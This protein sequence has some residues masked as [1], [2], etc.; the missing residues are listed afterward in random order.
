MLSCNKL[1]ELIEDETDAW[2]EYEYLANTSTS[3][4][5]RTLFRMLAKDERQHARN[6]S[7]LETKIC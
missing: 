3:L 6:L 4:R 7:L 2:K 5:D 1:K